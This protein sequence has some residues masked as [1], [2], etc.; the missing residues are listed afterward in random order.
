M[1]F[2]RQSTAATVVLG[3]FVDST[4]GVTAETGLTVSQADVRL[5]KNGGAFA[6]KNDTNAATH[7]E[8]GFYSCAL[9]TTDT[10]TVGTLRVAVSESGALPVW[11]EF[12]VVEEAVYDMLFAASALGY[13]ANA[14]VNV[15]QF[16][17]TNGTFSGGRPEVNTT[18]IEGSDATN[19]IR[20]AVVDDATRIDASAL[21]TA[22]TR[23]ATALPN[24]APSGNGGLPT[25]DANN[26]IVGIQGTIT[27]LDALDTAQDSQHSTTQG[28]VTTVDGVVDAILVDTAEIGAAGA[29]LTALASAANLATVDGVVDAIKAV[30]DALPDA[31][32][33]TSIAQASALATVDGVVDAIKAT[34]DKLDDTLEDQGGG[35]YGFTE[36][37]L[38]EAPAGGGSG[39]SAA[40]IAAAVWEEALGDHSSTSGSTAEALAAAGGAGDPWITPLPGSYTSGQAGYIIGTNLDAAVSSR[41]SQTSVNTVDGI[42]DDILADTADM[43]PKLGS[44]AGASI[45]ADIAAVKAQTA[46]IEADTQDLQAQVG[47]DGAGLTNIPWNASWDAEVQSECADA[48]NAYDPPTNAEM[49]ARTIAAASYA[50]AA[51]LAKVP[52]SDGSVSWNAT[53]LA[54]INAQADQALA[55][56][57]GPTRA[58][59]TADKEEIVA[60]I[61]ALNDLSA[62]EVNAEVDAALADYDPPTRAELTSDTNSVLSA[63]GDVPT[64]E[65]NADAVLDEVVEGSVT[66]RQ[67]IRLHNAALGGKAS[68]LET[69]EAKYRDLA[70]TKDRITATVDSDGNRTA[71]SRDLS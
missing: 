19:Q 41:A 57:D 48:L 51:E 53:A 23:V 43:Q 35:T 39:P 14:P 30:T 2:L 67:S 47:T 63:V 59:A 25:V 66:L 44:P 3:P 18:L 42:V 16:G 37:A 54:A 33:L 17:G 40:D 32:A 52:K 71:V 58:E 1:N 34:T 12:Q 4:D 29:G 5:S 56:Y 10:N 60:D 49:Q 28:L 22:S 69:T 55:D 7:M 65:E 21:N 61:A 15:A 62:A 31:G 26:R 27:T 38:Q 20:D 64:A 13:I 36:A 45:S 70:D 6:Q 68:G 24:A 50:T 11:L 8:N 46:A 9:N